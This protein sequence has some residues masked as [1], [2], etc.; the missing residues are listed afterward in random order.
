MKFPSSPIRRFGICERIPSRSSFSHGTL[1]HAAC[2]SEQMRLVELFELQIEE[3]PCFDAYRTQAAVR[4]DSPEEAAQRWP[5]FAPVAAENGYR[6][7]SA[8]PMRLRAQV[9]GAL[10]L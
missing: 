9:I 2:S 3:G 5:R 10:N 7:V 1:R 4:C 8:V 6:A